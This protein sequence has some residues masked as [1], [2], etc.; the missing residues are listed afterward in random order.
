M[1]FAKVIFKGSQLQDQ[2]TRAAESP[3]ETDVGGLGCNTSQGWL[4]LKIRG[5]NSQ[6]PK[7]PFAA[8]SPPLG[9]AE[10][11]LLEEEGQ[12]KSQG[13]HLLAHWG[14]LVHEPAASW[15]TFPQTEVE[16]RTPIMPSTHDASWCM[17]L[18][19]SACFWVSWA[20]TLCVLAEAPTGS[21]LS[22]SRTG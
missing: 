1:G 10:A 15:I 21:F 3:V 7:A 19:G 4:T 2:R 20:S 17:S 18:P 9:L 16:T 22:C 6:H 12:G 8:R 14:Q 13:C 11:L 5:H